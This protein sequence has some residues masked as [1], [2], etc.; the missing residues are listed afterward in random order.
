MAL[1]TA[2]KQHQQGL[3]DAG[4]GLDGARFLLRSTLQCAC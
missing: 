4:L 3:A 2:E 1:K